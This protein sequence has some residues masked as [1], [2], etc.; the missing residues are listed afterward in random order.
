MEDL[1]RCGVEVRCCACKT[2][3]KRVELPRGVN[4]GRCPNPDC[5]ETNRRA[6]ATEGPPDLRCGECGN[7]RFNPLAHGFLREFTCSENPHHHIGIGSTPIKNVGPL[8]P[9]QPAVSEC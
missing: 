8:L 5:P 1:V 9:P 4:I 3:L 6:S 2:V 7:G